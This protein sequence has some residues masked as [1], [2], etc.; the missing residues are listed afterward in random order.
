MMKVKYQRKM[1]LLWAEFLRLPGSLDSF[2]RRE[3]EMLLALLFERV[4]P[5]L[6]VRLSTKEGVL[7]FGRVETGFLF[8]FPRKN[9]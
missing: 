6:W 2:D 9:L 4:P 5:W 3:K 1:D 8:Y 7:P